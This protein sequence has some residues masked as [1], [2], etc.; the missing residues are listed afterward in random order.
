MAG[1]GP[2]QDSTPDI[3]GKGAGRA[4]SLARHPAGPFFAISAGLAMALPWLWLLPFDDPRLVH[5]RLGLFG[6]G[7]AAILGYVLTAMPAWTRR[8]PVLPLAA[9]WMLF[10]AGRVAALIWP[11]EALPALLAQV[12]L[13][14]AVLAPV[15][16]ARL[17][18]RLPL[19]ALPLLAGLAE[20]GV[21]AGAVSPRS[22]VLA[23]AVLVLTVGGRILP[24]FLAAEAARQ[25]REPTAPRLPLWP[26]PVAAVLAMAW[27][28]LG[29]PALMLVAAVMADRLR[30]VLRP[31]VGG[32]NRMLAIGWAWVLPGLALSLLAAEGPAMTA[33]EHL[34]TTGAMGGTI[35]AVASRAAMR[36][37]GGGLRPGTGQMAAF[38][39]IALAAV[40]RPIASLPGAAAG[41][42]AA[43]GLFWS[44]GWALFLVVHLCAMARPAPFPVLS[45]RRGAQAAS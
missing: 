8:G 35:M 33:A 18:A 7:G 44:L 17:W 12:A 30:P 29:W 43:S 10:L 45:A 32:A 25:G 1:I 20:A 15:A 13:G 24:A 37:A 14:G 9:L 6:F 21:I 31:G 11:W 3:A 19:A 26:A 27:P 38:A 23:M 36:R 42:L 34:I 22:I 5:L 41:W 2:G 40:L 39:L 4:R 16:A 28:P